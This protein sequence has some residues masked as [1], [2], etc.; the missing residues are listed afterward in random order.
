[1]NEEEW[2][3]QSYTLHNVLLLI[4]NKHNQRASLILQHLEVLRMLTM[5]TCNVIK[6]VF[7]SKVKDK[8]RTE[9]KVDVLEIKSKIVVI[10]SPEDLVIVLL[11]L[12]IEEKN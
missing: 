3:Q 7:T 1:M 12:K 2:N 6:K 4:Y 10:E 11:T 5:C 8:N 9:N